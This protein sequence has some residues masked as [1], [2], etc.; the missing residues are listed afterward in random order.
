MTVNVSRISVAKI[1]KLSICSDPPTG[2]ITVKQILAKV[3]WN[4]L[5]KFCEES[6]R[7]MTAK[8]VIEIIKESNLW[9]PLAEKE[10]QEVIKYAFKSA[11]LSI[12]EEDIRYTVGEVYLDV[13]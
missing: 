10:R 6:E 4:V 13:E 7:I 5:F 9:A 8:E 11:Q 3:A 12:P 1:Y 2:T